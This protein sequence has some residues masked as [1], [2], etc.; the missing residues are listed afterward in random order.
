MAMTPP[1][2]V[3]DPQ[4]VLLVQRLPSQGPRRVRRPA[5]QSGLV[6]LALVGAVALAGAARGEDAF[7]LDLSKVV[8][9]GFQDDVAG[10]GVG[11]WTDQGGNDFRHMPVGDQVLCGVS[12]RIVDPAK[13][14]GK[15]CLVLRGHGRK[16]LPE[17]AKV[18]VGR[19]GACIV[20][21]HAL[22]WGDAEPAA[23][24]VVTY[25]D[26]KNE[27]V[28]IR[29]GKEILGWWGA[30]ETDAV[31][32]A[33]Q[34]G[35]LATRTVCVHAW[36]WTNPRPDSPIE[37]V[38]FRSAGGQGMPIVVA[39]TVLEKAP[40]LRSERREAKGPT[41][42]FI[43]IEAEKF[44]AFNVPPYK[45]PSREEAA[46]GH[47]EKTY[48]TWADPRFSGGCVFQIKAPPQL[49]Q[50]GGGE[51]PAFIKDGALKIDYDFAA[52]KADAYVL[53]ARIGP[54]NVYS[55]FRWRVDDGEWGKITRQD[56]F[57]DMWEMGFWATLGWVRLGERRLEPGKHVLHIEVPRPETGEQL[58]DHRMDDLEDAALDRPE[59]YVPAKE[60]GPRGKAAA[61]PSAPP[62]GVMADCFVVTRVP[63]HPNGILKPGEEINRIPWLDPL[64]RDAILYLGDEKVAADG[65]RNRFWLDGV[66][67]MARDQEPI[68]S[69]RT[70]RSF[71]G[72]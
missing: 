13:N 57:L 31:K 58:L 54:A 62:W 9:M 16:D 40:A 70:R 20:F 63:F 36:A 23:H 14:G 5:A 37:S 64:A 1:D 3:P 30:Q 26:G 51:P 72:R 33:V 18:A 7:P 32:I 39:A 68:P 11:G 25:A 27:D 61:K 21:L 66:W 52:D 22:A 6:V 50:L 28:A 17:A 44:A 47:T 48:E 43:L 56:P 24:Y 38:E 53:W 29:P 45:D 12:F 46:K 65:T 15:G 19:K 69:P 60:R 71:A 34:S 55:P 41:D 49:P 35:N 8:N 67:E 42:G 59:G 10:D 2:K 4:R